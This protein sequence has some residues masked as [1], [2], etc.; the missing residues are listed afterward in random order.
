MPADLPLVGLEPAPLLLSAFK[1]AENGDGVVLRV[2]N[3]TAVF[4]EAVLTLGF[5]F[6]RADSLRLDE[7]PSNTRIERSG[8]T[9]RFPVPPRALRT[10]RVG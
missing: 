3:P 5:P 9:L 1:P 4:H 8:A 2:L 6:E 7:E 10:L